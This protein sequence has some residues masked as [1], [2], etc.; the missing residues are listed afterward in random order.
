MYLF[1]YKQGTQSFICS[2]MSYLP[3][4]LEPYV[5]SSILTGLLSAKEPVFV[6]LLFGLIQKPE[7][8][9]KLSTEQSPWFRLDWSGLLDRMKWVCRFA[10]SARK[11]RSIFPLV[12]SQSYSN[13]IQTQFKWNASK[14]VCFVE[15]AEPLAKSSLSEQNYF[16]LRI[17]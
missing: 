3:P 2:H 6:S 13:I 5:F 9:N 8:W 4:F 11:V 16:H 10:I 1:G 7:R 12:C 15:P 17:V 14:A